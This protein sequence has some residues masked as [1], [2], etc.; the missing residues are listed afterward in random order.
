MNKCWIDGQTNG[1]MDG[2]ISRWMDRLMDRF[3]LIEISI[4]AL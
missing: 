4:A 1:W 3:E 2:W